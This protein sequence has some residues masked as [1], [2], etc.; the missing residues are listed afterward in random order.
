MNKPPR[1][2]DECRR[3]L[4]EPPEKN[5]GWFVDECSPNRLGQKTVGEPPPDDHAQVKNVRDSANLLEIPEEGGR[6]TN[7]CIHKSK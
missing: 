4:G 1:K 3:M 7:I 5:L 2:Y 6:V